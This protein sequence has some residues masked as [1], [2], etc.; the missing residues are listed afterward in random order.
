ME[1]V[2]TNPLASLL[3]TLFSSTLK[4]NKFFDP[5]AA[6]H[7]GAKRMNFHII[8]ATPWRCINERPSPDERA[9]AM[10]TFGTFGAAVLAVRSTSSNWR[11]AYKRRQEFCPE[12][13]MRE[14]LVN[15]VFV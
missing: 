15:L 6:R 4:E 7:G 14:M 12:E 13:K 8:H 3:S 5:S 10:P 1:A 11:G 2:S 9:P